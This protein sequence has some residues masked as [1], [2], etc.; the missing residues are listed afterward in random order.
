MAAEKIKT[1][2]AAWD[3]ITSNW[4]TLWSAPLIFFSF[5][6][7]AIGIAYLAIWWKYTRDISNLREQVK[8]EERNATGLRDQAAFMEKRLDAKDEQVDEYRNQALRIKASGTAFS[9]LTNP[10]LKKKS[11]NTVSHIRQFLEKWKN[12]DRDRSEK[13]SKDMRL[14]ET[15][16]DKHEIWE[17][18]T[19]QYLTHSLSRN[20]EYE[21]SFKVS[22]ILLKDELNSRLPEDHKSRVDDFSYEHPTNPIGM[23]MVADDLE[24]LARTLSD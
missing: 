18:Y 22:T 19:N 17:K 1:G 2:N 20:A 9:K 15:E 4:E 5:L 8:I 21:K 13:Q 6:L 11:L 14:A 23:T 16:E 7:L 24:R 10:E 3:F 12:T